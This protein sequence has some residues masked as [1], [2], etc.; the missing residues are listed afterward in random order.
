LVTSVPRFNSA[1]RA[2]VATEA[3]SSIVMLVLIAKE[4]GGKLNVVP[5]TAL[6]EEAVTS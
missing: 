3:P 6:L 5:A 4:P 1:A 2:G